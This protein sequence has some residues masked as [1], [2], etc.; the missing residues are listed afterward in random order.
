MDINVLQE[1]TDYIAINKPAGI[2]VHADG[3]SDEPTIV[4]WVKGQYPNIIG[5]G[6]PMMLADKTVIER[7]GIV[8]RLDR[9][10]SGVLLIAKTQ[11]MFVHLKQQFQ[12]H[13]IQKKYLAM[14]YG[15]VKNDSG[16]ID[17]AI[18]RNTKD[19]RRW[20]AGRGTRG[21]VRSAVTR[22]QVVQRFEKDGEPF[23]LVELYPQTGRTH[24]LRVHMKYLGYPIIGDSLYGGKRL[25]TSNN[26]GFFRQALHAR[27]IK[28]SDLTTQIVE[29]TAPM[30]ADF[31]NV[32][33]QQDLL[34]K[35]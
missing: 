10:T 15:H 5:V 19:F 4:D 14:V 34:A 29:V 17:A 1:T 2:I 28:F 13:T 31:Q 32:L 26:L 35:D 22:Y 9:D 7:P 25:E 27:T 11:E 6:E 24:Q 18:G 3:K 21:T 16:T 23:T 33:E 30:P 20:H 8:H 12:D